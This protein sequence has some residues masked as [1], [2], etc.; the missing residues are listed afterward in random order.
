MVNGYA[1]LKN[2]NSK[3]KMDFYIYQGRSGGIYMNLGSKFF[4]L[5]KEQA[6][7][8]HDLIDFYTMI[9]DFDPESYNDF[10]YKSVK[11]GLPTT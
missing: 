11:E 3:L 6:E 1:V 5:T 7:K 4:L 8:M 9:E 2:K 10:Y